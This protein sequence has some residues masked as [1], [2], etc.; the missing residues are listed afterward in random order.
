MVKLD[1]GEANERRAR[2]GSERDDLSQFVGFEG[3]GKTQEVALR[4]SEEARHSKARTKSCGGD[5]EEMGDPAAV[6]GF[7]RGLL[8]GDH[9]NGTKMLW[10]IR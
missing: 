9:T 4:P 7:G 1:S 5:D 10:F 6:D 8:N 2:Q 3:L